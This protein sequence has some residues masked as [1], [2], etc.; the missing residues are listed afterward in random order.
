M[1]LLVAGLSNANCLVTDTS[2][3]CTVIVYRSINVL[4]K[5]LHGVLYIV[6]YNTYP[7]NIAGWC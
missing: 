2:A 5:G 1:F 4:G 6:L 3:A 7:P